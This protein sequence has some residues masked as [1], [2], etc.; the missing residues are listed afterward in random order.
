MLEKNDSKARSIR[1]TQEGYKY[2]DQF[3]TKYKDSRKLESKVSKI[4]TDDAKV[5]RLYCSLPVNQKTLIRK[6]I[7]EFK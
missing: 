2:L 3:G 6:L 5:M 1:I 4:D 7:K